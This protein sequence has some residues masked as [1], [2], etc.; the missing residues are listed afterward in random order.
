MPIIQALGSNGWRGEQQA[1]QELYDDSS[2]GK[3]LRE[4]PVCRKYFPKP[5]DLKSHMTI[6]GIGKHKC[7]ECNLVFRRSGLLRNHMEDLHGAERSV[8][9]SIGRGKKRKTSDDDKDF[10]P[11]NRDKR[12]QKSE[13][14]MESGSQLED[15]SPTQADQTDVVSDEA[16]LDPI[17]I[18]ETDRE[19]WYKCVTEMQRLLEIELRKQQRVPKVGYQTE[20]LHN[21]KVASKLQKTITPTS[22]RRP[23]PPLS[24]CDCLMCAGKVQPLPSQSTWKEIVFEVMKVLS[25]SR[26]EEYLAVKEEILPYIDSHWKSFC[27]TRQKVPNWMSNVPMILSKYTMLFKSGLKATGQYGYWAL[28]HE[29]E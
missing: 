29:E 8:A 19:L 6:H 10:R 13:T 7:S 21:S 2:D 18:P 27:G 9:E 4:C 26:K 16:F 11:Q 20:H 17:Q 5:H 23:I 14:D 15:E 1:T 22:Q 12:L 3:K 28:R 25:A 24:E